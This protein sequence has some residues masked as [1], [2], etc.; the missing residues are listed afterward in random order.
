MRHP[1]LALATSF[2]VVVSPLAVIGGPVVTAQSEPPPHA[3]RVVLFAA[4]GMRPDL[5][6]K[7]VAEG[8]MPSTA[9][10][11]DDGAVGDNGMT[12]GF[13]PNT[14]V[15]WTTMATGT[16]PGE[17]GSMNNTFHR[18]GE[19]NFNNRTA[20]AT[21][22]I[23][24]AD[25]IAQAAER[26]GKT[27]AAVEWVGAR[28]YRPALQGPVVDFRSFFSGRG[29]L[30]N[31]DLPGQPARA[32][33]FGVGYDRVDLEPA[34]GW[35]NVPTSFSPAMQQQLEVSGAFVYDLYIY[36]S[37]DD[38]TTNYD[39]VL[40][41]HT[42][43][44][45][46]GDQA[47]FDLSEGAWADVK[48]QLTG[49]GTAGFYVKAIDLAGDLSQFR[50]YNT[51]IARANATFNALG[52]AGSAAFEETLNADF[53]SSTAADFAP[54]EGGIIDEDTYAEQGLM[55]KDAHFAYLR[56]II[57][58]LGVDP[59]LL[60]V[61]N[62]ITDE[63][64][65]QFM[66]LVTPTD[67]DGDPNPFF[68]DV[69]NDDIADGRIA[70]REGFIRAAYAEADE[71]LTLAREL[72]GGEPTTFVGSDHGFAPQWFAVNAGK[73]LFDAGLQAG[74]ALSNCRIAGAAA[75]AM[76][77]A[78]WAGGTAEIYINLEG[79]DPTGVVDAADYE[80]VRQQIV[81]AFSALGPDVILDIMMKEELRDVDGSDSLHPS[82]SGDVVVVTRPPYQFDAATLGEVIAPSQF[83]GQHGY[84]PDLV[85]LEHNV[86]MHA[87]FIAAGPGVRAGATVD[88]VRA[89]DVAPTIAFLLGIDGP[90][91][92]RGRILYEALT[93]T[94]AL[95][96]I[97]ILDISD[98]HGQLTPLA[99][100]A[101]NVS[102]SGASNPAFAIGGSA[103]LKPWFDSYR[104]E[105]RDG[106]FTVAAGD[107][108][109]ATPPIS[110]FF[111]DTPTIEIMNLMGFDLDGLGN[112]NFDRGEAYLR[113][114]LIPLADFKYVS[115][116]I[117]DAATGDTP[118][119][120]SKSQVLR[121]GSG[122]N[123]IDVAVIGFSN[124]DIPELTT[125]GSLGPFVV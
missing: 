125:P 59:D 26:A 84:L 107:S 29:V 85:D 23:L 31:F 77:K 6:E 57:D 4:D 7:Y 114:T 30:L 109:G 117:V 60:L 36:D 86:N 119:E 123:A 50:L 95:R 17:H 52:A 46:D 110:A 14:G 75:Q 24:Q 81:D 118:E 34:A 70:E 113:E 43:A 16:W 3:D 88:D 39:H 47:A 51:S 48:V 73:V 67:I 96:E 69:E 62:P 93:D 116:N 25:T 103:F 101:D 99:E 19:G 27:V 2:A 72:M 44:G 63:F 94:A 115:A 106:H 9:E 68:D 122:K 65:H 45:K 28:T 61:G 97:T 15:G 120:W 92:A 55:W 53:P 35:T 12:Q 83:F 98:Y 64:S 76:A 90:Q 82:R 100:A 105:A 56:H 49:I 104:A 21:A 121:F 112:H 80:A 32:N 74:E 18:V 10:L 79:R 22:D 42:S 71:T 40:G 89:I 102:G 87:T 11:M 111:G 108:V 33:A 41:V 20:F 37:T 8:A 54:L 66:A 13:P 5:V 38:A 58:D 1:K 124:T 78:C 91:N